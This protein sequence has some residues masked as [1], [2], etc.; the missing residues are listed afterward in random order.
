MDEPRAIT[1]A[2]PDAVSALGLEVAGRSSA[3][4]AIP[5]SP[6]EKLLADTRVIV[7][8]HHLPAAKPVSAH[9]FYDSAGLPLF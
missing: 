5:I 4:A 1:T 3:A 9:E 2:D 7:A 6:G 8:K